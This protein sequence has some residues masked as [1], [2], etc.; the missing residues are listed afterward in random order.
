VAAKPAIARRSTAD[1]CESK[2]SFFLIFSTIKLMFKRS[3][4]G[5]YFFKHFYVRRQ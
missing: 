5:S 2:A 1:R 3:D 4:L